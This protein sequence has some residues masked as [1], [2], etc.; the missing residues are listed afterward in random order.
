MARNDAQGNKKKGGSES[1]RHK[2]WLGNESHVILLFALTSLRSLAC[3]FRFAYIA[4]LYF[5]CASIRLS[6]TAGL[7]FAIRIRYAALRASQASCTSVSSDDGMG[8]V[9]PFFPFL[10]AEP[11]AGGPFRFLRS[12]ISRK[13]FPGNVINRE[14]KPIESVR[15]KGGVRGTRAEESGG[16][17]ERLWAAAAGKIIIHR[18]CSNIGK[19][20][21]CS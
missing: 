2:V 8:C 21:P 14:G 5:R 20:F 17:R 3:S 13:P 9:L 19:K 18:V 7:S 15:K 12:G 10:G 11:T 1:S 4:A 16:E 6:R